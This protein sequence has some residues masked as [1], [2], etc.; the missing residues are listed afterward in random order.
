LETLITQLF[1]YTNKGMWPLTLVLWHTSLR[2]F[3]PFQ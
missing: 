3:P 1:F 2:N